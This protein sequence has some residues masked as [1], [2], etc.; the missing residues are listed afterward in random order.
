VS[1]DIPNRRPLTVRARAWP[2]FLARRLAEAG[3]SAN[4]VSVLGLL[5]AGAGSALLDRARVSDA[6]SWLC[7][8]AGVAIQLRLV[9]NLLDGLIAVENQRRSKVGELYNDVPDRPADVVLL[10]GAGFAAARPEGLA[11]GVLAAILALLTAYVRVLGGSLGFPHD[12]RGPMAKP[13]RMAVLTVG[14]LA[15]A[16]LPVFGT[17]FSLLAALAVIAVGTGVTVVRRLQRL[18]AALSAR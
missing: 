4:Q 2:H 8:A 11:L 3:V 13:Q 7:L 18:A 15:A 6:R 12:F 5:F 14:C 17:W 1:T 16:E 10:V 9:C